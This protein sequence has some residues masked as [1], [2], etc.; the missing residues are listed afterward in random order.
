MQKELNPD[1]S[2]TRPEKRLRNQ[3]TGASTTSQRPAEGPNFEIRLT[4]LELDNKDLK[5]NLLKFMTAFSEFT[6]VN[7][8]KGDRL[9]KTVHFLEQS[10]KEFKHEVLTKFSH[11]NGRLLERQSIEAKT[12]EMVERYNQILRSFEVRMNQMQRLMHE[13]ESQLISIQAA[14]NEAKAE[15]IRL[16]KL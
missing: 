7:Q 10:F 3:W 12:H 15:I 1:L 8:V 6:K 14:L 4:E 16:K 2:S 13:K 9:N 11:M 5:A